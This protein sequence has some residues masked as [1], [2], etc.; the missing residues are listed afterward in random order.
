MNNKS[1]AFNEYSNIRSLA[2]RNPLESFQNAQRV[3]SQWKELHYLAEPDLEKA[4]REHECFRKMFSGIGIETVMMP[5][6]ET[7]SLDSI[8]VRDSLIATPKGFVLASMGKDARRPEPEVNAAFLKKRGFNILGSI[9]EPGLMEG[10]DVVW[11]D[12]TNCAAG[13]GYR[14][15]EEGIHQL[16]VLLGPQITLHVCVLPH[17]H[18]PQGVFH[19]MSILSPLDRDLVLAHSPLMSVP[20][21]QMLLVSGTRIIDVPE[22]EYL[23]MGCNVLTYAPRQCL[24]LDSLPQTRKLLEDNG[25]SVRTYRGDEISCKGEGG[26]TCL[27]LPLERFV[28]KSHGV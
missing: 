11:L 12:D 13:L 20:F 7:L 5:G 16:R 18:G 19:L 4:V 23:L 28:V 27:T 17:Q 14:T 26:P 6:R 8:Y 15:N 2:L 22:E 1:P 21:R 3:R 9:K 25:C 10:G 24:M